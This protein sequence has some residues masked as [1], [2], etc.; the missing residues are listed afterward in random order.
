MEKPYYIELAYNGKNYH[1]WQIQPNAITIQEKLE[2]AMSDILREKIKLTGAGRTDTGVHAS[3]FVA[4]FGSSSLDDCPHITQKLN[5]Y[6]STDIKIFRIEETE[7]SFHSRFSAISRTYKY[8]VS[9][10]KQA[11]LSEYCH[12]VHK[13]PDLDEMNRGANTLLSTIDFTSFA[14]LH[15]DNHDNICTIKECYWEQN[16]GYIVFTIKANRFLRNM[17]RAIS[18]TLLDLGQ[19]KINHNDLVEIIESH[20]NQ[21]A[22]P[23]APAKGLYLHDIEYPESFHLKNRMRDSFLPFLG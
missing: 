17:V 5:A 3:Y 10:E 2:N 11:F 15:S 12:Y 21:K 1:G 6:L 8:V 19:A 20:D 9:P 18:S 4:H 14:K 23:S 16:A 13:K 7:K 22:S